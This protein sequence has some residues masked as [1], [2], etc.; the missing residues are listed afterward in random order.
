MGWGGAVV[1]QGLGLGVEGGVAEEVSGAVLETDLGAVFWIWRRVVGR[2]LLDE[3]RVR[4][5]GAAV[6]D[7]VGWRVVGD[8]GWDGV[9]G[10]EFLW[11]GV[12]EGFG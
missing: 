11:R 3:R 2:G 9:V 5:R 4:V 6:L 10:C 12:L 7:I 1:C 8:V